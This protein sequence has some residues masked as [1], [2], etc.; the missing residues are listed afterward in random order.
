[1]GCDEAE[2]FAGEVCE[3]LLGTTIAVD[4]TY[5]GVVLVLTD[6]GDSGEQVPN[7][8]LQPFPH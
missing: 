1:M 8:E 6:D 3:E 2:G 7:L 4:E 5:G